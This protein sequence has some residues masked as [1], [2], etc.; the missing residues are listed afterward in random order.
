MVHHHSVSVLLF[1]GHVVY[2]L[3]GVTMNSAV[4]N[5][6]SYVAWCTVPTFH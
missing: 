1:D 2:S 3:F 4:V 6:P 5:F